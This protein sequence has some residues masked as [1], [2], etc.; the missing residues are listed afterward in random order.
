MIVVTLFLAWRSGK[1]AQNIA[2]RHP[3]T[4]QTNQH[5]GTEVANNGEQG[6]TPPHELSGRRLKP[7]AL[8][9]PVAVVVHSPKLD[10]FPSPQPLSE[11]EKMLAEYVAGHRQQAILIARVRMAELKKDWPEE[12]EEASAASNHPTSDSPVIQQ[13]NR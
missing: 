1:P 13:E 9:G 7:R 2:A 12:M 3:P 5:D 8:S 4:M 10:Q 11:Q 6:S